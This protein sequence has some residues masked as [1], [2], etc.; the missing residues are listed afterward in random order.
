MIKA[1]VFDIDNTLYS[2]DRAHAVAFEALTEYAEREL[3]L[4]PERFRT[5]VKQANEQLKHNTGGNCAAIHNRLIRFQLLLEKLRLPLSHAPRMEAVYWN[6]L[7]EVAQI[8]P[9]AVECIQSLKKQGIRIGIGTDMTANWQF[10]KLER[11]GLLDSIDFMVSSEEA[12]IEKPAEHFF[13][14][15]VEKAQCL[16]KE[17]MF[18][19]D[20]VKKDVRG[21]LA[22][23]M[24]AVWYHPEGLTSTEEK[25]T[26]TQIIHS[27]REL[28]TL[29]EQ[30]R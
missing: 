18:V 15:C 3:L 2:F 1:V 28:L 27:F 16:P 7:L 25:P 30:S 21:A 17:C 12:S 13:A 23:G 8:E 20:N 5:L 29:V 10:V 24:N 9:Y 6:K 19:G 11:L 26:A 4:S 14:L 22:A